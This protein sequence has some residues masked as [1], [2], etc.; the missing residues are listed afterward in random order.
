MRHL[1]WRLVLRTTPSSCITTLEH[2]QDTV[3]PL[4]AQVAI[5]EARHSLRRQAASGSI[6]S[7]RME[8][9]V[10]IRATQQPESERGPLAAPAPSQLTTQPTI[11]VL[12]D[13][14][15]LIDAFGIGDRL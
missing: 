6:Y 12:N 11:P 5:P 7:G 14:Q 8:R 3:E 4:I 15:T 1:M 2:L 13:F 10:G 9:L